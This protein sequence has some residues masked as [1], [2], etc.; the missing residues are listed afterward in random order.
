[1]GKRHST[2]FE[3][4]PVGR[5]GM[6]SEEMARRLSEFFVEYRYRIGQVEREDRLDREVLG[7]HRYSTARGEFNRWFVAQYRYIRKALRKDFMRGERLLSREIKSLP[8]SW[9]LNSWWIVV[10]FAIISIVVAVFL[11][12]AAIIPCFLL[13]FLVVRMQIKMTDT[14]LRRLSRIADQL[15]DENR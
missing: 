8:P 4:F 10:L 12:P 13:L 2:T 3:G 7:T 14:I 9:R 1:M 15:S 5:P 6:T 11:I